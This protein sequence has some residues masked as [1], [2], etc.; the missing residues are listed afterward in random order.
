MEARVQVLSIAYRK[1][2]SEGRMRDV[3]IRQFA[4]EI[5]D[6]LSESFQRPG[7]KLELKPTSTPP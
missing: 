2:F 4:D 5:F 6:N 7:L 3:R 1:A